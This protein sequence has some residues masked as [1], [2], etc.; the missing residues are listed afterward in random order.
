MSVKDKVING[1]IKVEGGYVNDPNDPGGETNMGITVGVARANG[2][3]G[4]MRDLPRQVAYRIYENMYW[5][6]LQLD[7]I[8]RLSPK[9]AEEM[10]DTG[11]NMGI[12]VSARFLQMALNAVNHHLYEELLEDGKVGGKTMLAL[13]TFLDKYAYGES[14]LYKMLNCLQGARYI[15]LSRRNAKLKKFMRGWF[16]HRV[17]FN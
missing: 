5:Q 13:T 10:A 1:I 8:E 6:P 12:A 16:A 15:E 7:A 4:D 11:V 14:V 17:S 2:Y 9:I 3:Y